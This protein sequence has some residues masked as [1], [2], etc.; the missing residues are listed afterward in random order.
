MLNLEHLAPWMPWA[1]AASAGIEAQRE[2]LA[3]AADSWDGGSD[4]EFLL[5][6]EEPTVLGVF[7]LHRRIGPGAI[8]MGYWL[9]QNATGRGYAT[10]AARALTDAALRLDDVNTVEIHCD[11]ANVRSR[12]VPERLGYRLERVEEDQVEAPAE[13]GRSMIWVFPP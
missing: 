3:R 1:S 2:R 7:G 5:V 10:T 13:V 9:S 6:R 8:E 12:R 4:F 11:Q